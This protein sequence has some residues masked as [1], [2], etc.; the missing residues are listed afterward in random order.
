MLTLSEDFM[1]LPHAPPSSTLT[2][3]SRCLEAVGFCGL[4]QRII[5]ILQP[6]FGRAGAAG[7]GL[8]SH[9]IIIID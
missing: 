1:Q 3:V 8:I 5:F 4:V 6:G 7:A 2:R 9:Q